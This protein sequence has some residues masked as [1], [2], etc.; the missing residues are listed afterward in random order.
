[1]RGEEDGGQAPVS[2]RLGHSESAKGKEQSRNGGQGEED[3]E[4]NEQ[5]ALPR[6]SHQK[7][8]QGGGGQAVA[9]DSILHQNKRLRARQLLLR[10]TIVVFGLRSLPDLLGSS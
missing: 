1:M 2:R 5:A 6:K 8:G 7:S 9:P 10:S 4:R 3:R